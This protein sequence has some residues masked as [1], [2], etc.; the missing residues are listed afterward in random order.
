MNPFRPPITAIRWGA[1]A[2]GLVLAGANMAGSSLRVLIAAAVL[3]AYAGWRTLHPLRLDR[4][5]PQAAIAV[6][7]AVH[8]LVVAATGYWAS[9]FVLSLVTAVLVVG[10]TQ[11]F[12]ASVRVSLVSALAV[13]VP[14][15]LT[16]SS[17][18]ASQVT[19]SAQWTTT[20]VLVAVAAGYARRFSI[21][22]A[23]RHGRD[24]DRIDRLAQANTLLHSLHDVAQTL[25]SSLD[26]DEA[27]DS[28]VARLRS[29]YDLTAVAVLL[30][31]ESGSGWTVARQ[32]GARL[33][34][35]LDQETLPDAVGATIALAPRARRVDLGTAVSG[36][37][38]RSCSGLYAPLRAR[39]ELV[40][41]VA[42]EHEDPHRFTTRDTEVLDG[43]VEGAALAI[44]NA[45]RFR[46]LRRSSADEER[47]RIAGE[48][49][50]RVGQSLA[51]AAF[52]ID[53]LVRHGGDD[54]L[55]PGL[56][57]LRHD[58]RTVIAEI[59]DTLSDLRSDVTE[60]RGLV[61]TAEA[62]LDRVGQRSGRKA[63]FHHRCS[64]RLPLAQE[65]AM[66]RILYEAVSQA[67][68][69][70]DCTVEV[71]WASDGITAELEVTTD[72]D[73]FDLDGD[74]PPDEAW[75]EELR[76]Q[77]GAIGAGIEFDT[78]VDGTHRLRCWLRS[79]Q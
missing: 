3:A 50:D 11:G 15:H 55:R 59:R 30:P 34:V 51:C 10:F 6:E 68:R 60:D 22:V 66:W 7:A 41:I 71:W 70:G 49:H 79:S 64:Q 47:S 23:E 77:A 72:V 21:E 31:D 46:R 17:P 63:L 57:G 1:V 56:E 13:A 20:L 16:A 62:F 33:A 35:H 44:D 53:L 37:T 52:Q 4:D 45:G 43:F 18:E 32:Q 28:V 38:G 5:A 19:L 42:V 25:P 69:R 24:L 65:R 54:E 39:G 27:L 29:F 36:L 67:L 73:G 2:V 12:A 40:G 78:P 58:L 61:E 74:K 9:P 14:Y 76:N 48:L 75:A 26:L 8:M